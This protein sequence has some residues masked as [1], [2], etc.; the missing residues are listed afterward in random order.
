ME[1]ELLERIEELERKSL[2]QLEVQQ[3]LIERAQKLEKTVEIIKDF[4]L[5]N[6]GDVELYKRLL[7]E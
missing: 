1:Q 7:N 3:S 4:I 2:D 6:V 5:A